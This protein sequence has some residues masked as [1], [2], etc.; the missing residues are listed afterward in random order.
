MVGIKQ[1]N[2]L[3]LRYT[4]S[5]AQEIVASVSLLKKWRSCQR[6]KSLIGLEG[7]RSDWILLFLLLR[8]PNFVGDG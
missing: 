4:A 1:R 7:Q 6:Q 8:L 3:K 2:T 5:G